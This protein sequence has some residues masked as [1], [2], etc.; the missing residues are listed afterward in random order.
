MQKSQLS[1]TP[2]SDATLLDSRARFVMSPCAT[3]V[4]DEYDSIRIKYVNK[5]KK[6]V[7]NF[8]FLRI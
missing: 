1:S 2:R 8:S 7:T 4:D 5:I 6:L 3:S